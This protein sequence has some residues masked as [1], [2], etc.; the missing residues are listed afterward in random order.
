MATK[1]GRHSIWRFCMARSVW[2]TD[3][4][5]HQMYTWLSLQPHSLTKCGTKHSQMNRTFGCARA[6]RAVSSRAPKAAA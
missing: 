2:E 5:S 3:R 4:K 6:H 1:I